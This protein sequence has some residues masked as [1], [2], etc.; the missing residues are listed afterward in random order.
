MQTLNLWSIAPE[1][2]AGGQWRFETTLLTRDGGMW[3]SN[4]DG[5]HPGAAVIDAKRGVQHIFIYA[6][7]PA[8]PSGIFRVTRTL[9]TPALRTSQDVAKRG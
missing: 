8:G 9:D 7:R 6:G 5:L 4:N 1:E 3:A 2:I